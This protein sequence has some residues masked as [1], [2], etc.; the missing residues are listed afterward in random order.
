MTEE[1]GEEKFYTRI[2]NLFKS[3]AVK[4]YLMLSIPKVAEGLKVDRRKVETALALLSKGKNPKLTEVL[5][6]RVKYYI[7]KE[8]VEFCQNKWEVGNKRKQNTQRATKN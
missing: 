5:K 7:L 2:V 1:Q 8:L 3:Q 4:G 6:G